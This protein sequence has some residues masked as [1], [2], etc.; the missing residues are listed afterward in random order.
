MKPKISAQKLQKIQQKMAKI[1]QE[2]QLELI[3]LHGSQVTGQLHDQSDIDI[4]IL[5]KKANQPLNLLQLYQK[6]SQIFAHDSKQIDIT[7]LNKV[8]P[9]GL[10]A[11]TNQAIKL[12]GTQK[13]LDKLQL[14]ALHLYNDYLPV[15]KQEKKFLLNALKQQIN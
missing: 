15:L 7:I 12:A 9:V 5:K 8:N 3:L 1:L 6:I 13:A 2:F 14:K 10:K 11:M 4:G